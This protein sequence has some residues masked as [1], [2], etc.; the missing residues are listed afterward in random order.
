MKDKA[1]LLG[2]INHLRHCCGI[3]SIKMHMPII[4]VLGATGVGKSKLALD[5]GKH[6]NVEIINVDAMQVGYFYNFLTRY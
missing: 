3:I 1:T 2:F 6:I 5:I 4:V